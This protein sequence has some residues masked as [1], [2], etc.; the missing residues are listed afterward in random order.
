MLTATICVMSALA[1]LIAVLSIGYDS[2]GAATL[3][4]STGPILST[5]SEDG[6]VPIVV[7]RKNA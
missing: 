3:E 5:I 4:K 7:E 6:R 1:L 2:L